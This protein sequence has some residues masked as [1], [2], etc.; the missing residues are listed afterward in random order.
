MSS[1]TGLLA[2]EKKKKQDTPG[3]SQMGSFGTKGSVKRK[4][5]SDALMTKPFGGKDSKIV[6]PKPSSFGKITRKR[7][8]LPLSLN[9]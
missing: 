3:K 8:D 2:P 1:T 4:G 6:D 9:N 7:T 5:S